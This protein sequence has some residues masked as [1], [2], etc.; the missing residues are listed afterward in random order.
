MADKKTLSLVMIV[1]NEEKGLKRAVDSVKYFV[2]EII[3]AVDN[4]SI[5][6]TLEI[7]KSLTK[8]IKTF[9]WPDSYAEARNFA[10]EGAKSDWLLFLD[11]HEYVTK[12]EKL[13]EFLN[14]DCDGL[15]VDV[16][17]EGGASI[18]NPRI[19]KNGLKF[20]QAV[21]ELQNCKKAVLYP[22]FKVKHGRSDGQDLQSVLIRDKQRDDEVPRLLGAELKKNPRHLRALFHLGMHAQSKQNFRLA[23]KYFKRYL[24]Y[25][26][27]KGE[28]WFILFNLSL[29]QMGLGHNFRAFWAANMADYETPGRWEIEKL[30]GLIYF[31]SGKYDKA[32]ESFINSFKINTIDCPY[33]PWARDDASTWNIIGE[34]FF[35]LK[36][37]YQA[38]LAFQQ[39]SKRA[40][41]PQLK[42][43]TEKRATLMYDL[44]KK[45]A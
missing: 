34:S 38:F 40:T 10:Q 39:S 41:E 25:S 9:D 5:D 15:V 3:I 32:L 36:R 11:G 43:L 37:Y 35:H 19:Y 13:Q 28:R 1:K 23:I 18:R 27:F 20:E 7:A 12:C 26:K 4:A 2:D 6:K 22:Y 44:T 31:Q 30:K 33:K 29:C 42:E 21:H 8:N 14:F 45:T 24:K 16:E 17:I